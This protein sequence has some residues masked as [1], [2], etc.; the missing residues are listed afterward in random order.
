MA[1]ASTL[2]YGRQKKTVYGKASKSSWKATNFFDDSDDEFAAP[3]PASASKPTVQRSTTVKTSYPVQKTEVKKL[4]SPKV[5]KPKAAKQDTFDVP[6]SEDET[7]PPPKVVRKPAFRSKRALVDD[8]VDGQSP[9]ATWERENPHASASVQ[10]KNGVAKNHQPSATSA[11]A[12]LRSDLASSVKSVAPKHSTGSQTGGAISVAEETWVA[13]IDDNNKSSGAAARLA[14]RKR[15]AEST[16]TSADERSQSGNAKRAPART[17]SEGTPR[18]RA[19]TETVSPE[20]NSD[21]V[22]ADDAATPLCDSKDGQNNGDAGADIYDFPDSSADESAN[23]RQRARSLKITKKPIRR[24]KPTATAA[25]NTPK[26]GLSAPARLAE[27]LP[28]DSDITETS[29]AS[30]SA[31]ASRGTTP[32]RPSTPP[33]KKMSSPDTAIKSRG[34][35][36]PKQAELWN[37]LIPNDTIA[38][39]PSAL[40]MKDLTI[41]GQSASRPSTLKRLAKSQSDLGRRRT[42]LVDRLK[43]SAQLS[44]EDESD[45]SSSGPEDTDMVDVSEAAVTKPLLRRAE[46]TQSRTETAGGSQSQA[47]SQ[48][49]AISTA[50][51]KRTY[52]SQRSH[53]A[54]DNLEDDLRAGLMDE[55]PKQPAARSKTFGRSHANAKRDAFDLDDSE[56]EAGG[57]G[58]IRSIHELRAAGR[59]IRGTEDIEQ[60]LEDIENHKAAHKSRRRSALIELATKLA[61]K[62]FA[63]RFIGQGC[64]A[65]LARQCVTSQDEIASFLLAAAVALLLASDPP[66][67]TLR[68]LQDGGV[69]PWL[70]SLL[71]STTE[72]RK[73]AKD[74]RNN[75]ARASQNS[76]V[77]LA[78]LLQTQ[79]ILWG[80]GNQ[81]QEMSTCLMVRKALDL[82]VGKLRRAGDKSEILD[83]NTVTALLPAEQPTSSLETGLAISVLESLSTAS[84]TWSWDPALLGRVAT[85]LTSLDQDVC[86][87]QHTL[88]L[89][90]RLMLNLTTVE[91]SN[92][93]I[94]ATSHPALIPFL[95]QSALSGFTALTTQTSTAAAEAFQTN[96]TSEPPASLA[97]TLDLLVLALGILINLFEHSAHARSLT[98]DTPDSTSL[99]TSIV[100]TFATR[101]SQA[102]DAESVEQTTANIPLGYLAVV[103]ANLCQDVRARDV[104]RAA[105]PE[106]PGGKLSVLADAVEEFAV[107]HQRVDG[108]EFEGE[109]GRAV[110]GGF[111]QKLILVLERVRAME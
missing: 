76:L 68:T 13:S 28:T 110:M 19:R 65:R 48:S 94:L 90:L 18:K 12:Q 59:S 46:S 77:D 36:T 81:P 54:E 11:D 57:T 30:P 71:S 51:L 42:R 37:K 16:A 40:A 29:T 44:S 72:V 45:D 4:P 102:A 26:K 8:R 83:T 105:L 58:G 47:R 21:V 109:E 50:G 10:K 1:A 2:Q 34:N 82:L 101:Q 61:D 6:S 103:L 15:M 91:P 23:P 62:N 33:S 70:Q 63:G 24:G 35:I 17:V 100:Q 108:M 22:M 79:Q 106:A 74:R 43:A 99:T 38:P 93:D 25:R 52:A 9:L 31:S 78:S 14:A 87:Q 80:E 60:L 5:S 41:S 85:I 96:E 107:V 69:A 89:T 95:L 97:L 86:G 20:G 104:V 111:T 56:D 66:E 53:M 39:S 84:L 3:S 49:S 92:C 7:S 73:L 27:M 88:F 67:H 32:H 64:D 75:M 98:T 55:T